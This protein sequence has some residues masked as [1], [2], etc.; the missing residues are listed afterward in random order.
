ME[1]LSRILPFVRGA[2]SAPW[3]TARA[4][5]VVVV[6]AVFLGLFSA[7]APAADSGP[8][9]TRLSSMRI[10]RPA[11]AMNSGSASILGAAE[12]SGALSGLEAT[13]TPEATA[14]PGEEGVEPTPTRGIPPEYLDNSNQTIRI[15]LASAVLVLI[16]V[17]GVLSFMPRKEGRKP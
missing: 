1:R 16:V 17:F 9:A 13:V 12:L 10:T 2:D 14:Q 15:T 11:Y 6:T 7:A 8:A 5:L 3:V 4:L